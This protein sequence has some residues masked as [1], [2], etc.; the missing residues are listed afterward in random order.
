MLGMPANQ[1]LLPNLIDVSVFPR[2]V[3]LAGQAEIFWSAPE[4]SY[5]PS[6]SPKER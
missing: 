1:D 5:G 3:V 2:N 4:R 6:L